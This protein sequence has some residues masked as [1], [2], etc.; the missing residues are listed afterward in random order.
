MREIRMLPPT[1]PSVRLEQRA[2]GQPP[3]ITGYGAVFYRES[4]PGT[5][6]NFSGWWDQFQE[7]IMP[8]AFDRAIREDDVRAL[9]NHSPDQVLGRN[10]SGTMRL[11]IDA[12]GL[13][14]EIDPPNNELGRMVVESIRR[15]DVTGSS[16]AFIA[17]DITFRE[18]K[19]ENGD[20]LVIREINEVSLFDT[21]PV[22]YPAYGS[23]SASVRS[24]ECDKVRDDYQIWKSIQSAK[25]CGTEGKSRAMQHRVRLLEIAAA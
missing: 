9:F 17:N 1:V 20:P 15:G 2:D 10:R 14:Y 16:F 18:V 25:R 23:S 5:T 8:G 19:Q 3:T 21:G 13:R 22:T 12:T 11:S 6:Y 4:D 7:R 24:A